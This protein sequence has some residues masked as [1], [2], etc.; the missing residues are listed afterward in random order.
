MGREDK[1][2]DPGST[3][4]NV[5]SITDEL[6]DPATGTWRTGMGA[7]E[8]FVANTYHYKVWTGPKGKEKE[9]NSSNEWVWGDI[10]VE[11]DVGRPVLLVVR[12]RDRRGHRLPHRR[13]RP[14]RTS[15]TSTPTARDPQPRS[16]T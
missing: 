5:P 12:R 9:V 15:S 13:R 6:I 7:F 10:V 1:V 4:N 16:P 3:P 8:S 11:V 14:R 2:G